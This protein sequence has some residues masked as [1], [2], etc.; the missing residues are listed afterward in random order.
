MCVDESRVHLFMLLNRGD[1]PNIGVGKRGKMERR[2][3]EQ[4]K[5]GA[6]EIGSNLPRG[7][8][9]IAF[10][11]VGNRVNIE[12]FGKNKHRKSGNTTNDHDY[13]ATNDHE[14]VVRNTMENASAGV[15]ISK[16]SRG[17]TPEPPGEGPTHNPNVQIQRF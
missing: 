7:I 13:V 1:K 17:R 8:G 11:S 10:W 15:Q 3:S 14:Y 12:C 9:K 4:G 2:K 6:S 16:F 5:N